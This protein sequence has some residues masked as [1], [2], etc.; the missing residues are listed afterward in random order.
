[1]YTHHHTLALKH[2]A[3]MELD[4]P[5]EDQGALITEVL[6]NTLLLVRFFWKKL[7]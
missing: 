4:P 6:L 7:S 3:A 5:E 2:A 1:M